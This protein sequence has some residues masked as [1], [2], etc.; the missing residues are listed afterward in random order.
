[1]NK[2]KKEFINRRDAIK[3]GFRVRVDKEGDH[4]SVETEGD[5]SQEFFDFARCLFGDNFDSFNC[6]FD[7]P[8]QPEQ[9]A[10]VEI[11]EVG[12]DYQVED[13]MVDVD[14]PFTAFNEPVEEAPVEEPVEEAEEEQDEEAEEEDHKDEKQPMDMIN[15]KLVPAKDPTASEVEID[16]DEEDDDEDEEEELEEDLKVSKYDCYYKDKFI[17]SV[18]AQSEDE[19]YSE[20]EK[21]WPELNYGEYDGVANVVLSG[22]ETIEEDLKEQKYDCYYKDEFVGSVYAMSEDEAYSKMEKE[23]PELNYGEYDGVADVALSEDPDDEDDFLNAFGEAFYGKRKDLKEAGLGLKNKVKNFAAGVKRAFTTT[24]VLDKIV[25]FQ[26]KEF[27][28]D[29]GVIKTYEAK[30]LA[31][32][33]KLATAASKKSNVDKAQVVAVDYKDQEVA[34]KYKDEKNP[35]LFIDSAKKKELALKTFRDGKKSDQTGEA[36]VVDTFIQ[37]LDAVEQTAKAKTVEAAPEEEPEKAVPEKEP[38]EAKQPEETA[39]EKEPEEVK[40]PEAQ[41]KD[42]KGVVLN[43]KIKRNKAIK[44]A[45]DKAGFD[46]SDLVNGN[47]ASDKLNTIRKDLFGE[48]L[49]ESV[50]LDFIDFYNNGQ[51]VEAGLIATD[52]L[53]Y[54]P[55]KAD[56]FVEHMKSKYNLEG[57]EITYLED[58]VAETLE[59]D[60]FHTEAR[61]YYHGKLPIRYAYELTDDDKKYIN[62]LFED[63]EDDEDLEDMLFGAINTL[64]LE[65]GESLRE[66]YKPESEEEKALWDKLA[67]NGCGPDFEYELTYDARDYENSKTEQGERQTDDGDYIRTGSIFT[68]TYNGDFYY[69]KAPTY[70]DVL[71]FLGEDHLTEEGAERFIADDKK[72]DSEFIEFLTDKYEDEALDKFY[73]DL[74]D[75]KYDDQ[76]DWEEDWPEPDYDD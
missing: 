67:D 70:E 60:N 45:L 74:E 10:E 32:A 56:E 76:M 37:E 40:Q 7:D 13:Q 5:N 36:D 33:E 62:I 8:V 73:E 61:N 18:Y 47:K 42:A 25:K 11:P 3:E 31:E 51:A 17:G 75:G 2:N 66:D 23:W 26:V 38:A 4:L 50:D 65:L 54:N 1:M 71:E 16:D 48:G 68:G 58:F 39:K 6:D 52:K 9:H 12:F 41:Q 20:M 30:N 59:G 49:Q 44:A 19:A 43:R 34:K 24:K 55:E 46:T 29:G 72:E 63:C 57:L 22:K 64:A 28:S 53:L 27:D 35:M 14:D 15:G 69:D 21:V